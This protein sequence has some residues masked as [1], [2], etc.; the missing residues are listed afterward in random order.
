MKHLFAIGSRSPMVIKKITYLLLS[1]ALVL[2]PLVG[3]QSA[4]A[5]PA[6]TALQFNG[7]ASM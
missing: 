5:A 2:S 4:N 3:L 6:G 7:T 1:V